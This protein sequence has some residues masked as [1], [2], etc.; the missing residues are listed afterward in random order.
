MN[1]NGGNHC[2]GN[3]SASNNGI[4]QNNSVTSGFT[5]FPPRQ[6]QQVTYTAGSFAQTKFG[7][8]KLKSCGKKTNRMSP[9]EFSNYIK[10]RAMQKQGTGSASTIQGGNMNTAGGMN[11]F[12]GMVNAGNAPVGG[13]Q[14]RTPMS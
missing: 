7:S 13:N 12:G 6:H 1:Q 5:P 2:S 4:A 3:P 9:T 8:T 10:Q 14:F 11:S